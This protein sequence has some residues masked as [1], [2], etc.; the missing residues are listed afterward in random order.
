MIAIG[1]DEVE[2]AARAHAI[3]RGAALLELRNLGVAIP[4]P[5]GAIQAVREVSLTI[6][7]GERVAILGESGCGK[8]MTALAMLGLLPPEAQVTGTLRFAGR[9]VR[10]DRESEIA[11][12]VRPHAGIVFQDSLA[13][14]NP[15][16]RIGTQLVEALQIRGWNPGKAAA[17]AIRVLAHVGIPDAEA[18]MLSFPHE[19]SGGMRQRVM[20]T[21]ALLGKPA[22]FIADEPT[23]ALD[24]TVQAQV[25]DL[26]R[27][28]QLETGM[29]LLLIT[30][31]L[32]LAAELCD[33][34]IVMYAGYVVEDLPMR[35]LLA[36][37]AHPYAMALLQA[38]PRLDTPRTRDLDTIK[39]E[40][41][42]VRE[43][44]GCCPFAARCGYRD[45]A[46]MTG[47]PALA[48]VGPEHDVRCVHPRGASAADAAIR[49]P[50]RVPA[51]P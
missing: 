17:E 12:I 41:P 7:A 31:D 21:M 40:L 33:R 22:L 16:T 35:A 20:I 26:I 25:I 2:G 34:A 24:T 38:M 42:P 5:Q 13:C 14:L 32:A 27:S 28:V 29:G 18:R 4:H 19:L 8:T 6:Q 36:H 39:G 1:A 49:G 45:D 51:Q 37:P 46:C 50:A 43:R 9:D 47:I 3:E 30:H 48:A 23:T 44:F 11:A 10:L 15:V